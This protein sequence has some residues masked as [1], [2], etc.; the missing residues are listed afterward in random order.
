MKKLNINFSNIW[1]SPFFTVAGVVGF[2]VGCVFV[3][4]GTIEPEDLGYFGAF[5]AAMAVLG[6]KE[7]TSTPPNQDA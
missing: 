1:K 6:R 5:A 2:A 4:T 7:I 3:Y